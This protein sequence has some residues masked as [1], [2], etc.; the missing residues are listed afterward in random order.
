MAFD[1]TLTYLFDLRAYYNLFCQKLSCYSIFQRTILFAALE[2]FKQLPN[3]PEKN[4]LMKL[5]SLYGA[6]L[7]VTNYVGTLFEGGFIPTNSN[8]LEIYQT[9]LINILPIIKNDAVRLVDAIAFPDFI[10][11][12]PLGTFLFLILNEKQYLFSHS[13]FLGM[14]DGEVSIIS[15]L[16]IIQTSEETKIDKC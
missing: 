15:M 10:I 4:I 16:I 6:N 5:L 7:I 12:S 14:S 2:T 11:N 13:Y 8:A 3:G 9:G 1:H